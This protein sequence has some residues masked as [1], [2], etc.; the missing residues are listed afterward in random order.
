[1]LTSV[2]NFQTS[3]TDGWRTRISRYF[4]VLCNWFRSICWQR[5]VLIIPDPKDINDQLRQK[6]MTSCRRNE[7]CQR[8]KTSWFDFVFPFAFKKKHW[9]ENFFSFIMEGMET[10]WL[11]EFELSQDYCD[12]TAIISQSVSIF[13]LNA[14]LMTELVNF[15]SHIM[16]ISNFRHKLA[17][18]QVV[19]F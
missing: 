9:F 7:H 4:C 3:I 12:V 10:L 1:M 15:I 11:F 14:S 2:L 16:K 19:R 18:K 5:K 17:F 13:L 6:S 8:P